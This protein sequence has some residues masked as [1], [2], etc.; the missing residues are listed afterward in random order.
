M[1]PMKQKSVLPDGGMDWVELPITRFLENNMFPVKIID[2]ATARSIQN[3]TKAGLVYWV[4]V[5]CRCGKE[6]PFG[7]MGQHY[8]SK[9][10]REARR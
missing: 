6:V 1:L 2:K 4:I 5:K 3:V 9:V 7:K 8:N 10:C